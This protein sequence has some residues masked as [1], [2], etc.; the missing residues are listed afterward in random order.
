MKSKVNFY[1]KYKIIYF[2]ARL[3]RSSG[4]YSRAPNEPRPL[5]GINAINA[6]RAVLIDHD[7]CQVSG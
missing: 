1:Y 5:V 3:C 7:G 4:V 6:S 2:F